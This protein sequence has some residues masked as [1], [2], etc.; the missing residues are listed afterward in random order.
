M[1]LVGRRKKYNISIADVCY[2]MRVFR[3]YVRSP[4]GELAMRL[5]EVWV[6]CFKSFWVLL[7]SLNLLGGVVDVAIVVSAK[8]LL[9][10]RFDKKCFDGPVL[11]F[12]SLIPCLLMLRGAPS[13]NQ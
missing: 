9:C 10:A 12:S 4:I 11:F 5:V 8:L 6:K 2:Y 7:C 1:N 13:R 3:P